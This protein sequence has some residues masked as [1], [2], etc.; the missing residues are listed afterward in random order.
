MGILKK[1]NC[2][3]LGYI[4]TNPF[5]HFSVF[6]PTKTDTN[7]RDHTSV[8]ESFPTVHTSYEKTSPWETVYRVQDIIV[9][10]N[11]R[12]RRFRRST[13][14][15]KASVLESLLLARRFRK[16][17]FSIVLVWTIGENAYK[18]MRFQTKTDQC[19]RGRTLRQ[20]DNPTCINDEVGLLNLF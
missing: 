9:F 1:L 17:P 11:L 10:E 15:R 18:S 3:V 4:H 6:N 16:Y 14:I 13:L 12:F 8:F 2:F 20:D 7:I 5:S 19:G